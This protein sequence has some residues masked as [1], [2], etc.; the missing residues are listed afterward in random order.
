MKVEDFPVHCS[1]GN[2]YQVRVDLGFVAPKTLKMWSGVGFLK[3]KNTKL[4]A[5]KFE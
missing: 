1:E 4:H 2:Y 5:Q 3:T